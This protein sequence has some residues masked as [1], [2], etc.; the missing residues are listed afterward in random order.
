MARDC[1]RKG[2]GG[3]KNSRD[4]TEELSPPNSDQTICSTGSGGKGSNWS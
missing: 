2:G 1:A 3:E 4:T